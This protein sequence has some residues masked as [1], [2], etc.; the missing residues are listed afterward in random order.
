MKVQSPMTQNENENVIATV[1][2]E[3]MVEKEDETKNSPHTYLVTYTKITI[4]LVRKYSSLTIEEIH[5]ELEQEENITSKKQDNLGEE[6]CP[7][8]AQEYN[9][10]PD[11]EKEE[12]SGK[13]TDGRHNHEAPNTADSLQ[14]DDTDNK[15]IVEGIEVLEDK[16]PHP[17]NTSN[18]KKALQTVA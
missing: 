9:T 6:H 17:S 8:R 15:D 10:T 18:I 4:E 2:E 14:T 12:G 7:E 11:V 16:E 13:V 3:T 1:T 5:P